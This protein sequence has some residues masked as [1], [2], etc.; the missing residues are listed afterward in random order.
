MTVMT[1]EIAKMLATAVKRLHGKTVAPEVVIA[2][3]DRGDFSSNV[4]FGLA[5]QLKRPP[6]E[7]A[8]Q[9]SGAISL[10]GVKEIVVAEPGF[11]NISMDDAYWIEQVKNIDDNFTT[12]TTG[13]K[14]KIQVEFISANPTGPLTLANARGGY[15][16]DVLS[17]ILE[18]CGFDVT[19]EYYINDAGVQV[20]KLV[21]AVRKAAGQAVERA[22]EYSGEYVNDIA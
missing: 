14:Q 20:H 15:F 13:K 2:D 9:I 1:D 6:K 8:E 17:N 3:G 4:A 21:Q 12:N 7:I 11:I 22:G 5:K 16:G 18:R 19:R 10:T